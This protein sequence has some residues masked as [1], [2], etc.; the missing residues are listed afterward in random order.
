MQGEQFRNSPFF[1]QLPDDFRKFF[2][3]QPQQRQQPN[4]SR[5]PIY[6]GQGSGL[7]YRE[8]GIIM[9]NRHV[10]E[11]SDRVKIVFKDG[12]EFEGEILGVDRESDIAVIKI[13]ATGL[14]AVKIGD[15]NNTKAGVFAI[16]IGSPVVIG[17]ALGPVHLG[18]ML[19]GALLGLSLIHI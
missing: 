12:K 18:G 15:S 5:E 19:A 6:D 7:V 9:T 13:E 8:D 16:A 2:E 17:F 3:Q 10:V 11:N 1:D 4:R 14:Q